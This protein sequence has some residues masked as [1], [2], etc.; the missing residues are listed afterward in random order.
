MFP[1]V[2]APVEE[3]AILHITHMNSKHHCVKIK[4]VKEN[5]TSPAQASYT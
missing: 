3:F 1:H 2:T 4:F 5:S